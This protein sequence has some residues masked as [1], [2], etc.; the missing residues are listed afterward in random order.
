MTR[1]RLWVQ[2]QYDSRSWHGLAHSAGGAHVESCLSLQTAF[3]L[4]HDPDL[5]MIVCSHLL[6]LQH[7]CFEYQ[8]YNST[9]E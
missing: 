2:T 6:R 5:V 3:K 1:K 7:D 4:V 9:R 8:G